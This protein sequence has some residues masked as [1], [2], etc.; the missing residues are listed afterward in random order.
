MHFYKLCVFGVKARLQFCK[1]TIFHFCKNNVLTTKQLSAKISDKVGLF[2][3]M[4]NPKF[5]L[6]KKLSNTSSFKTTL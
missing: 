4:K 2:A 3:E 1:D 6:P 5:I